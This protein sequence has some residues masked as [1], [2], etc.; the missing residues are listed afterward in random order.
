MYCIFGLLAAADIPARTG[1][2]GKMI[3]GSSVHGVDATHKKLVAV[4]LTKTIRNVSSLSAP[5][6]HPYSVPTSFLRRKINH[7][8]LPQAV[9]RNPSG[10]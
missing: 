3:Y 1:K 6:P 2:K 8:P 7:R 9:R 5:L 4:K 10:H